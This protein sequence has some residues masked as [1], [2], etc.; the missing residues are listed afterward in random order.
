MKEDGTDALINSSLP[1]WIRD[2]VE[3]P[4]TGT[5]NY[6]KDINVLAWNWMDISSTTY[7]FPDPP[8]APQGQ[9]PITKTMAGK[10]S[11][12]RGTAHGESAGDYFCRK[13]YS[14]RKN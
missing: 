8:F 6:R 11:V 14:F 10:F 13:W 9:D 2:T 5:L 3:N 4:I 12:E 7:G 1:S